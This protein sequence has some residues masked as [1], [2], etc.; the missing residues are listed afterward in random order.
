MLSRFVV[1]FLQIVY[2]IRLYQK[3]GAQSI[4]SGPK[5]MVFAKSK[6]TF[7]ELLFNSVQSLSRV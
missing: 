1:A 5:E 4:F 3:N 2:I 7:S 6:F